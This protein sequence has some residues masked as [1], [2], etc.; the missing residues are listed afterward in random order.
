[1]KKFEFLERAVLPEHQAPS[2]LAKPGYECNCS[3]SEINFVTCCVYLLIF[4]FYNLVIPRAILLRGM[5]ILQHF[6]FFFHALDFRN[7]LLCYL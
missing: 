6:K 7:T 2:G 3:I 5:N 4:C 1:M